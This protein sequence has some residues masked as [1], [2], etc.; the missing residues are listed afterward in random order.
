MLT[1]RPSLCLFELIDV[2]LDP[3]VSAVGMTMLAHVGADER[4]THRRL[5]RVVP[6]VGTKIERKQWLYLETNQAG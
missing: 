6:T 2:P 3:D 4:P 5:W 1:R